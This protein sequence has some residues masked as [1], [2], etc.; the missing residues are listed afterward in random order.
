M[1]VLPNYIEPLMRGSQEQISGGVVRTEFD[2]GYTKQKS[3]FTRTKG[4]MT[5]N[6]LLSS[7]DYASFR[8]WHKTDIKNGSGRFT[9]NH[10]VHGLT[11]GQILDGTFRVSRLSVEQ[12][13]VNFQIEYW[14]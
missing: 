1:A 8:N 11:N 10:P 5:I 4:L 3:R 6:A 7:A 2:D 12:F 14:F 13:R 9:F